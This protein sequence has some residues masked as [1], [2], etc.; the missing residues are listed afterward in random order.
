M[1]DD[2][3]LTSI[4]FPVP[5]RSAGN[6]IR[7]EEVTFDVFRDGEGF[8]LEPQ[9][10]V[11]QLRIANLPHE[12]KFSMK[13]GKPESARGAKDGNFHVITDAVALLKERHYIA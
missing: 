10:S 13:D 7:Q 8:V 6:S 3:K 12:L 11:D 5:I 4:S 9:L 2:Y 1:R